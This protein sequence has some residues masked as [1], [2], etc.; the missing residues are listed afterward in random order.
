M[1]GAIR[2]A[3]YR[4]TFWEKQTLETQNPPRRR[5]RCP[6]ED[7]SMAGTFRPGAQRWWRSIR[8]YGAVN[9][10]EER[11]GDRHDAYSAAAWMR[12][13]DLDGSL[14]AFLNPSLATPERA[15]AVEGWILGVA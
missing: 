2:A 12:R 8:R 5:G 1:R 6:G 10:R 13:A 7:R 3:S 14:A 15:V 4:A 11:N 9:S